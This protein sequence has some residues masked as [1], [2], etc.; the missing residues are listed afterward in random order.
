LA[1]EKDNLKNMKAGWEIY[2]PNIWENKTLSKPPT[3][4]LNGDFY[5]LNM[6]HKWI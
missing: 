2:F 3:S 5:G 6:N 1:V 4:Q